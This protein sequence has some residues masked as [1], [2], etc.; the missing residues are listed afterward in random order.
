MNDSNLIDTTSVL[1]RTYKT[2]G[3]ACGQEAFNVLSP[4]PDEDI[5]LPDGRVLSIKNWKPIGTPECH[6][7]SETRVGCLEIEITGVLSI[8]KE[9]NETEKE[10]E[11]ESPQ[12]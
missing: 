6:G 10:K 11:T 3:F 4:I 2:K 7:S 12:E 8:P 1:T 9:Q 5:T